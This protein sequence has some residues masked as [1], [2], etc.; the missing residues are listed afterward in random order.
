MA[1]EGFIVEV[2][3]FISTDQ[4]LA[5]PSL[6]QALRDTVQGWQERGLK[7]QYWGPTVEKPNNIYWV[8]FWQSRAHAA[9]FA[10][11]PSYPEFVQRLR[12]LAATPV[13]DFHAPL[14][15]SPQLYVE[16]PVTVVDLYKTQDSR[17]QETHEMTRSAFQHFWSL[18]P[19]G[20]TG[21][22]SGVAHEDPTVG[23][24]LAGWNSIEDHMRAG[25][26]EGQENFKEEAEKALEQ[27]SDLI[28]AHVAFKRH[29]PSNQ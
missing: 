16:A 12:S 10:A 6:L 27:M 15:G 13:R 22:S 21:F 4:C 9:A 26:E 28:I 7:G 20:F 23:V 2:I 14:S 3:Q 24:C 25:V 1:S 17:V 18:Q 29:V 11:D 5:D 8:L 19:P